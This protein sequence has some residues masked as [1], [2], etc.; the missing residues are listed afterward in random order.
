MKRLVDNFG[1]LARELV[2]CRFGSLE[3]ISRKAEGRS[4]KLKVEV[5][6]DRCAQVHMALYHNI[7]KRPDTKACPSC[8]GR[9]ALTV[10]KWLYQRCQGQ[11]ERCTN[12]KSVAFHRYGGR[13]IQFRFPSPNA[14]AH[15]IAENLGLQSR[16][17]DLD[18]I[19]ND[20][21]YEPG[22]LRWAHK[23]V[24]V[25]NSTQSKGYRERF[26]AFRAGYPAVTYSDRWLVEMISRGMTDAEICEKFAAAV[27]G[28]LLSR[29]GTLSMQG[30]YRDLPPTEG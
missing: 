11:K 18:R 7:R 15:W 1:L 27:K 4:D 3:I 30:P 24:N 21:H 8:N 10:P 23:V 26:L 2:G 5:R 9:A 17:M 14:A 20:G 25:A 12:P 29:S 22:N 19:D 6:C 16:L 13:G 28:N